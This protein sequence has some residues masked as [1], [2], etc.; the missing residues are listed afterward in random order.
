M[1]YD[2]LT[3][4]AACDHH[5]ARERLALAADRRTLVSLVN[6]LQHLARPVNGGATVVLYIDDVPVPRNH[7]IL[8]WSLHPDPNPLTQQRW[9]L[10]RFN[11]LQLVDGWVIE[12]GYTTTAAY[13]LKCGAT[14]LVA[15][16]ALGAGGRWQRVTGL[17]KLIQRCLKLVLTSVCPFYPNLVCLLRNQIGKKGGRGF[18][19]SDAAYSVATVLANLKT[20]Q[21]A[22]AKFQALDAD[23][24]LAN[25]GSVTASPDPADPRVIG[26]SVA[27]TAYS[28]A[29]K[30]LDIG[31]LK[32]STS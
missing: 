2:L 30:T 29:Q 4:P 6:P 25:V 14:G 24:L 11:R 26:V 20:I 32:S 13:C 8:G 15:D 27:L 3:T 10:L 23:E 12:V 7:P 28:G 19:S 5:V 9:T 16:Y 18:S 17:A 22:Q 31:L 1:S 21:Q